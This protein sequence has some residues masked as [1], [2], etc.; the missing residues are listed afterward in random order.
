MSEPPCRGRGI[1]S[2]NIPTSRA[3]STMKS[4]RRL[5]GRNPT[6]DD[7]LPPSAGQSCFRGIPAALSPR[8]GRASRD[9]LPRRD[10]RLRPTGQGDHYSLSVGNASPSRLLGTARTIQT[11]PISF[12]SGRESP[13][14]RLLPLRR[15]PADLHRYAVRLDR[16]AARPGHDPPAISVGIGFRSP[17]CARMPLSPCGPET[18]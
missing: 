1:Y 5:Q 10:Q 9:H 11:R 8:L 2:H 6:I 13:Q 12:L 7:L 4:T 15:R 16:G 3:T 18:A 14:V 17:G